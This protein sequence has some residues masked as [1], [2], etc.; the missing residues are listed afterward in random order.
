MPADS[1]KVCKTAPNTWESIF[2]KF[3]FIVERNPKTNEC[4]AYCDNTGYGFRRR[5]ISEV[6]H[7][8]NDLKTVIKQ[9]L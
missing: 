5:S 1:R 7:H 9:Q 6:R 2:H 8:L 4:H 3:H